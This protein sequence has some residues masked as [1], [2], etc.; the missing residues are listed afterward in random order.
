MNRRSF[1]GVL[2]LLFALCFCAP[3][4]GPP[5]TQIHLLLSAQSARPG[6]TV[7]AGLK[8]DM[9]PTWHTYWRYGGDAGEPTAIKWTL[10]AGVTAGPIQWPV[11]EKMVDTYGDT[12]LYTYSYTNEVILLTPLVLDKSLKPGPLPLTASVSW[13][14][15]SASCVPAHGDV[16][17]TLTIA[18]QA[19]PS[20]D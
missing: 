4:F 3:A 7:W 14:E 15:C 19:S 12:S 10:P 18:D 1:S 11:P 6:D 8:M 13:M 2:G 9:P 5:K 16:S 17:A 20:P